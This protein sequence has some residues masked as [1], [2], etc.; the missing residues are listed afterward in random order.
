MLK[1]NVCVQGGRGNGNTR[2]LKKMH[3]KV[4]RTLQLLYIH[5]A[6]YTLCKQITLQVNT[7]SFASF[8]SGTIQP[9]DI[10]QSGFKT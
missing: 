6:M 10:N 2:A 8:G 4:E 7:S 9:K 5:L 1:F 3:G